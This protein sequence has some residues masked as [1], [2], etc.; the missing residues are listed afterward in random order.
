MCCCVRVICVC[1]WNEQR[2]PVVSYISHTNTLYNADVCGSTRARRHGES[3][4]WVIVIIFSHHADA[5]T[6]CITRAFVYGFYRILFFVYHCHDRFT[7]HVTRTL[8][9]VC[10]STRCER[11]VIFACGVSSPRRAYGSPRPHV[12]CPP[13]RPTL[14]IAHNCGLHV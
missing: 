4:N 3:S 7:A 9:H 12:T 6:C 5:H 10:P 8:R 11:F 14:G 2:L 13:S 1:V